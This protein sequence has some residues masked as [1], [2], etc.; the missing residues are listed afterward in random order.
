MKKPTL[1]KTLGAQLT[2]SL[3][4]Y[5][6]PPKAGHNKRGRVLV[7][8]TSGSSAFS[9]VRWKAG[10]AFYTFSN[11][12]SYSDPMDKATFRD[13]QESQSLGKWWNENWR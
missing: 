10:E 4:E 11:G 12:Y 8:D 13:W 2:R 5:N 9:D 6:K 7:A 3:A 1:S